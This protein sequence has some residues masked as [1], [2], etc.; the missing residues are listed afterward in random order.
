MNVP[1]RICKYTLTSYADTRYC[2]GAYFGSSTSCEAKVT[3]GIICRTTLQTAPEIARTPLPRE[4]YTTSTNIASRFSTDR[5]A[6]KEPGRKLAGTYPRDFERQLRTRRR[7]LVIS[8]KKLSRLSFISLASS[9]TLPP[10]Y[11][12]TT[13]KLE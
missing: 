8:Q 9:R 10:Q 3:H 5:K 12:K 4:T 6:K 2:S 11:F 13:P 1:W 7:G